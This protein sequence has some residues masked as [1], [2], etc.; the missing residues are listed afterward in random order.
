MKLS[1]EHFLEV[2]NLTG[3]ELLGILELA[4]LVKSKSGEYSQSLKDKKIGLYFQKP[5]MRTRVS[6]E[7]GILELGASPINLNASEIQ[8]GE[9]ESIEDVSKVLSRYIDGI[10]MRVYSHSDLVRFSGQAEL[11]VINGLSDMSHPC[12]AL[13]DAL[14]IVEKKGHGKHKLV[15]VGDGNNVCNSLLRIGKV[16]GLEMCVA[17][18]HG[19]EPFVSKGEVEYS[20][21]H[22]PLKAAQ[23]ADIIYTDVW[24]SMGQEKESYLRKK[25]FAPYQVNTS[26]MKRAKSDCIFMHCLPAHRGEEVSESVMSSPNSVVI[27]QA[28]NRLHAQKALMIRLFG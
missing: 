25:L 6:F 4:Q 19:Y 22:D 12:Q 7:V 26:M 3:A 1:S 23:N 18:P 21:E 11:G 2:T 17:C 24:T 27:D 20:I 28:E 15:Y 16:L 8:L 13:A 5:S 14:T 9:R 10:V